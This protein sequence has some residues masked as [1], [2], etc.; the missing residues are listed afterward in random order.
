M[1]KLFAILISALLCTTLCVSAFAS[2]TL[3]E[4]G[5][6]VYDDAVGYVFEIDDINGTIEGEDSTICTSAAALAN[7][8]SWAIWFVA[9]K[10]STNI[11]V[12]STDG[13]A[14]GGASP[15]VS[16][17]DGQIIVVVH[18]SSSNPKDDATFP[19]WESKV[20]ALAV[21]EGDYLYF[22]NV[23]IAGGTSNNGT[24]TVMTKEDAEKIDDTDVPA[25]S[26]D[27]SVETSDEVSVEESEAVSQE[28]PAAS[29]DDT[30]DAPAASEA[31]SVAT[32]VD[33]TSG[34][35]S[36]ME[37]EGFPTW[38][39]IAIAAGVLVV[40]AVIILVLKKKK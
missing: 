12:A 37:T 18:S 9:D 27:T 19:N 21:E 15:S 25:T 8:G 1:K 38:A 10:V 13:A 17:E 6:A 3:D 2:Y 35:T 40:V 4:K 20:A 11:Y 34:T 31:A 39:W 24:M 29:E 5:D 14:M 36:E 16:L 32:S 28:E 7:C 23:D 22:E 33:S 30:T 26:E